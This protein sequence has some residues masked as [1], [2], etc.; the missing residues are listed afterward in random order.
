MNIE[1]TEKE[2]MILEYL[3]TTAQ[4]FISEKLSHYEVSEQDIRKVRLL[5][6][7]NELP[8]EKK[9]ELETTATSL[10]AVRVE[11]VIEEK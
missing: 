1:L 11:E 7:F 3:D 4:D 6:N 8:E 9:V 2:V 10:R 5:R